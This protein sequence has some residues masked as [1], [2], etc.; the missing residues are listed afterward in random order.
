MTVGLDFGTTNSILSFYNEQTQSI[1]SWKMGGVDGDNY[2]PSFLSIDEDNDVSIGTR[3]K[4]YVADGE[5]IKSY[6]K[7]KIFL[8]EK[9]PVKLQK[10]GF[11]TKTPKEVAKLYIK[12]L[13]DTFKK[14]NNISH[15]DKIVVS[16]PEIW[17]KDNMG[18][19]SE[20]ESILKDL[21]LPNIDLKSEPV[22]AGA[23]FLHK[24]QEKHKKNFNGH[25]LVFDFG[26]GTLDITLLESD[27]NKIK[28]LERTGKGYSNKLVGKAGVAYDQHVVKKALKDQCDTTL[29]DDDVTFLSLLIEFER[30]KI[31]DADK[32]KKSIEKYI[33]MKKDTSIFKIEKKNYELAIT[34]SLLFNSF[35]EL[36]KDD[37][38]QALK[39]IKSKFSF[40]DIDDIDDNKF[41]IVLV[42]G[43]SSFYL[44]QKI[45]MDFFNTKT[46]SDK[47][48][49]Q[50]FTKDDLALAI[51]KGTALFAKDI[52][53]EEKTYP[54]SIG[55][56][57]STLNGDGFLEELE[58]TV[59]KKGDSVKKLKAPKYLRENITSTKKPVLLFNDGS[60]SSKIILDHDIQKLFP[61][62]NKIDNT[63][64]IGFS[65]DNNQFYYL[66]IKDSSGKTTK[67]EFS[68]LVKKFR[69]AIIVKNPQKDKLLQQ[70]EKLK[71]KL[72]E[73]E[74]HD[75][76]EDYVNTFN[77]TLDATLDLIIRKI[78]ERNNIE[79]PTKRDLFNHI[80]LLEKKI[81]NTSLGKLHQIR[82]FRNEH[83]H[84]KIGQL[85]N[86]SK[87]KKDDLISD[88]QSIITKINLV[89]EDFNI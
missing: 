32:I 70:V 61:N 44:S 35:N 71:S 29:K 76:I 79:L 39:E 5:D 31:R 33:K 72:D 89:R 67:T 19:R 74:N 30:K 17:I 36:F 14:E 58:K 15:I 42:G 80:N 62:S 48:F 12:T 10:N 53:I 73:V 40:Y 22:S 52:I 82:M 60:T 88:M 18:V 47:R 86:I 54:M 9:D 57:L 68:Y 11:D 1:E 45:V 21:K 34:P 43:F 3:V 63:W 46:L 83:S 26:G 65:I 85:E 13:L 7:F 50:D 75:D 78:A 81:N 51:S 37:I 28:T 59:F 56:I 23:Y 25:F 66:H 69:D 64:H 55:I 84:Q 8:D 24:Y 6:S 77:S 41:K 27:N 2:I 38:N 20:L 87:A 49:E 4:E 16:I